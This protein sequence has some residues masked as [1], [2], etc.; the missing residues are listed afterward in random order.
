MDI[1][2]KLS[3]LW[4]M[5]MFNM[6]LADVLSAFVAFEDKSVL[7]LPDDIKIFMAVAAVIINIPIFMIYL[8]KVLRHKLNRV[9]NIVAGVITILFVVGGASSLPHYLVIGTIEV[10]I[11]CV[12]I[13]KSWTWKE[14]ESTKQ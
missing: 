8:S 7:G 14:T 12:I 4:I 11:L 1:K 2:S 6:I 5:V 3:T 13:F 9:S 10:L